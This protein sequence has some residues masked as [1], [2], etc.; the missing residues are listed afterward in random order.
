MDMI[1]GTAIAMLLLASAVSSLGGDRCGAKFEVGST[2]E[3][4]IFQVCAAEV[5][6][7]CSG[8]SRFDGGVAIGFGTLVVSENHYIV[9]VG[10][11][12][13]TGVRQIPV[14]WNATLSSTAQLHV[15]ATVIASTPGVFSA[16]VSELS[17]TGAV[18]NV[19][20]VDQLGGGWNDSQLRVL[21]ALRKV[22][23]KP[24]LHR[25]SVSSHTANCI[26]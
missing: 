5:S 7:S 13:S 9:P 1:T 21:V 26:V 15:S 2:D 25:T 14:F 24:D 10:S 12:N 4:P 17:T 3:I 23:V 16:S 8:L 19:L 18:L 6:C 11:W 20:R 22:G